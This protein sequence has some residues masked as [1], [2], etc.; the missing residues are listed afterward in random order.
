LVWTHGR[1]SV[2]SSE[3]ASNERDHAAYALYAPA[4][5]QVHFWDI[6]KADT[7]DEFDR[8]IDT[9]ALTYLYSGHA[10][11]AVPI[12][13]ESE[14]AQDVNRFIEEDLTVCI[15][16]ITSRR[17]L[18]RME[19]P[20]YDPLS[21]APR[22]M[23]MFIRDSESLKPLVVVEYKVPTALRPP[24]FFDQNE[25]RL[26]RTNDGD[27]EF[28]SYTS[29]FYNRNALNQLCMYMLLARARY[30]V[31]SSGCATWLLKM[32]VVDK[33]LHNV[34]VSDPFY[35]PITS[36][37]ERS[38]ASRWMLGKSSSRSQKDERRVVAADYNV[39]QNPNGWSRSQALFYVTYLA[40]RDRDRHLTDF[41]H[42][43]KR[44]I[45]SDKKAPEDLSKAFGPH[46]DQ[47]GP[48]SEVQERLSLQSKGADSLG[49]QPPTRRRPSF[50]MDMDFAQ[51][52]IVTAMCEQGVVLL[53]Q[54]C[55]E[56]A[57][58]QQGTACV[59]KLLGLLHSTKE[60]QEEL[61]HEVEVYESLRT[62]Q[63]RVIPRVLFGGHA[64]FDRLALV[65]TVE[66]V[67]LYDDRGADAARRLGRKAFTSAALDVLS[68]L[69]RAGYLHGDI[70]L[71]NVVVD[72]ETLQVKLI[73]LGRATPLAA[74]QGDSVAAKVE[75]EQKAMRYEINTFFTSTW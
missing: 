42:R 31:L 25:D 38:F 53:D 8:V 34:Y 33:E 62:L 71:R 43:E 22:R 41:L 51:H 5:S 75:G 46:H 6:S 24:G 37:T 26:I 56:R 2:P 50:E 1:G 23:D 27:G 10:D 67:T 66:G 30:G 13:A 61:A 19:V 14:I 29:K 4:F 7:P 45:A 52:K 70:A 73:D 58:K 36:E 47:A 40:V 15:E 68:E 35:A 57:G 74:V 72:P 32:D 21:S 39:E 60:A 20:C 17:L 44:K 49:S 54:I 16:H 18:S 55:F 59:V 3:S 11:N 28:Y 69:H 12:R 48:K 9:R 65:L 63:G 64:R